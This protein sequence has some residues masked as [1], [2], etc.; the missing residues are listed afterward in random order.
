MSLLLTAETIAAEL[1]AR[2]ATLTVAQGAETD[3]G[4]RVLQGKRSI[5]KAQ[6]PWTVKGD[7]KALRHAFSELLLNAM[8]ANPSGT[9]R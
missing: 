1:V 6:I 8:Q 2:M 7:T 4:A 9:A 5:D 3:I